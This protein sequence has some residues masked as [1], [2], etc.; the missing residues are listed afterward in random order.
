M[1]DIVDKATRSR[2]MSGI[3][4]ENT[5][6]EIVIRKGLHREGFRFRLR[7]FGLPGKPDIVLP[8]YRAVILVHGCFWH[9]HHCSL[10]KLPDTRTD[11]WL[12]KLNGNALRDTKNIEKLIRAGWRVAIVWECTMRGRRKMET[13]DLIET[14]ADWLKGEEN[15]IEVPKI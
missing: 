2:M 7:R 6:P 12:T 14:L 5:K 4:S 3:R 9:K 8:K 1:T 11:F 15:R 13:V 10:F